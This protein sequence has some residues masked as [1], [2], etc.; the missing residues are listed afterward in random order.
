MLVALGREVH[1]VPDEE[2]QEAIAVVIQERRAGA[3]SGI[4]H[5]GLAGDVG[6]GAIAVVV[7]QDVVPDVC[8]V[9]I[10][11]PIVV[12]VAGRC[13]HAVADVTDARTLG[14]IDEVQRPGGRQLVLEEPVAGLDAGGRREK[15]WL[16]GSEGGALD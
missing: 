9:Q 13:P 12:I 3:P 11:K 4:I 5:P 6:E 15:R 8:H 10:E 7:V 14:H 16:A 1:V 2:I